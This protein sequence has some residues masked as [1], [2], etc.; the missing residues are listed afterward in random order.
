MKTHPL[1]EPPMPEGKEETVKEWEKIFSG[2]QAAFGSADIRYEK[3]RIPVT[4][5]SLSISSSGWRGERIHAQV[6]LWTKEDIKNVRFSPSPFKT[7]KGDVFSEKA[8]TIRFIRYGFASAQPGHG[9]DTPKVLQPDI[10][11]TARVLDIPKMTVRPVWISIDIPE[12]AKPGSYKG[13]IFLKADGG[14][15]NKLEMHLKVLPH[16]LPPPSEWS[17]HLDLW[18]NPYSVARYHRVKPWSKEHWLLLE[19]V[20]RMLAEAGQK[21]ITTTIIHEPW[22]GQTFDAFDSMIEWI[23]GVDGK[24]R[25]DYEIFD[26]YA[27][28]CERCGITKQINCYSMV[29]WTNKFRYL[30]EA[31]GDY[32]FIEAMPG[33]PEYE[34]HWEPFLRDFSLHVKKQGWLDKTAIAMDERSLEDMR[35]VIAFVK[36]TAPSLKIALAGA[37]HEEIRL[38][39]H[40][41]CLFV[42]QTVPNDK[43]PYITR[44]K[45]RERVE[46]GLPTTFYVCCGPD[47]PNTF[48]CSPPA[49]SAWMGWHAAALGYSGFLRWAYNSWVEDPLYD[50]AHVNWTPG[51][52]FLVYPGGRSS[53]RFERLREGI[54]DYE[55]VWI[56][57]EI[58]EKRG[59]AE[60][61]EKLRELEGILEQLDFAK[62]PEESCTDLVNRAKET[63]NRISE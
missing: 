13:E 46:R 6:V 43:K 53:I 11:D 60:S 35:K 55:K 26:E 22:G 10:L 12:D 5:G 38:D 21:C 51:D 24:W 1:F 42:N 17:F 39:A 34:K 19:P 45:I 49:E 40:D 27:R 4:S 3:D 58:L 20:T 16:V 14:M 15:E 31:S 47:K 23:K 57:R 33:T 36:K 56:V 9:P 29:P 2:L 30:D 8:V 41:Y 28:F 59:D 25:F 50:T 7:E 52:C 54:Q 61:R 48:P 37:Y 62:F 63:L 32:A 44:E 18:Q